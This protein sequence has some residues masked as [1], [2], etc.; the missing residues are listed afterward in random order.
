MVSWSFNCAPGIASLTF[1]RHDIQHH[2]VMHMSDQRTHKIEWFSPAPPPPPPPIGQECMIPHMILTSCC[3]KVSYLD[4]CS[5]DS[6]GFF[7]FYSTWQPKICS[8]F[9]LPSNSCEGSRCFFFILLDNQG[10]FVVALNSLAI[11]PCQVLCQQIRPQN[12]IASSPVVCSWRGSCHW[13]F[14]VR[15][16][17]SRPDHQTQMLCKQCNWAIQ[18]CVYTVTSRL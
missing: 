1:S 11:I 2:H 10:C 4:S 13:W 17:Y 18:E 14:C 6:L 15:T 3:S 8:Y 12:P 7:S 16:L 9:L 5:I